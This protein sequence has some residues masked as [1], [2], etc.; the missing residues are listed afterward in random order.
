MIYV[1]HMFISY[2]CRYCWLCTSL[3]PLGIPIVGMYLC[4]FIYIYMY[5]YIY[6][7]IYI[8]Y[9]FIMIITIIIIDI[10]Y[11]PAKPKIDRKSEGNSSTTSLINVY[12]IILLYHVTSNKGRYYPPSSKIPLRL[13]HSKVGFLTSDLTRSGSGCLQMRKRHRSYREHNWSNDLFVLW[14]SYD[15]WSVLFMLQFDTIWTKMK[16]RFWSLVT[17]V[18]APDTQWQISKELPIQD[19]ASPWLLSWDWG[20]GEAIQQTR[21]FDHEVPWHS[22]K[23]WV[24]NTKNGWSTLKW[25]DGFCLQNIVLRHFACFLFSKADGRQVFG[26]PMAPFALRKHICRQ[27]LKSTVQMLRLIENLKSKKVR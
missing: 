25:V 2:H 10:H 5:I 9:L 13:W 8:Y 24:V 21:D 20:M 18:W 15:V 4:I 26:V 27:K 22:P 14:C 11:L 3:S 23:R 1:L 19:Q 16:P 7:Y 17:L 6:V 12:H